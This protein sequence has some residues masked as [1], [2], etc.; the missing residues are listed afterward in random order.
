M[1]SGGRRGS[2][3]LQPLRPAPMARG[4]GPLQVDVPAPRAGQASTRSGDGGAH[5]SPGEREPQVGLPQD[6]GGAAEPRRPRVG[7]VGPVVPS[8]IGDTGTPRTRDP[9]FL[10]MPFDARAGSPRTSRSDAAGG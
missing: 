6:P 3:G 9:A 2:G 4:A 10:W 1:G 7:Q 5:H 8:A